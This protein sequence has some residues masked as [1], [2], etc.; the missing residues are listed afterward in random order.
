MKC[1]RL[2]KIRWD[3]D[4]KPKGLNLPKEVIIQVENNFVTE[5]QAADLLSDIFGFC[6]FGCLIEPMYF[7][8]HVNGDGIAIYR[9]VLT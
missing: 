8:K 1:Y 2:H 7:S 4:G 5:W 6:I 3:T 9:N